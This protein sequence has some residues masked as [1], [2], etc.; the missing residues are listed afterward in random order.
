MIEIFDDYLKEDEH[1]IIYDYFMGNLDKGDIANSMCWNWLNGISM[2]GDGHF[3]L[4]HQIFSNHN[5]ISPAF[6][7]M[8]PILKKEEVIGLARIKAN[9]L[10][11]TE[12]QIIF[13]WAFHTDFSDLGDEAI[14]AIYY[15]NSNDGKTI[16]E[17]GKY[18]ESKANRLLRFPHFMKHTGTTCTD[19]D[20]RIIINF[21]YYVPK[22]NHIDGI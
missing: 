5:V 17:D 19:E 1:Q 10:I 15:V 4:V 7:L 6:D 20:R 21:N 12:E 3:Q 22:Y 2:K 11:K 14:T 16:F 9:C 8:K 13:D 18:V